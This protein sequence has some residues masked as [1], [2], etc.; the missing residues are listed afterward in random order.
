[1]KANKCLFSNSWG[2]LL[3][4]H[5]VDYLK[6][7]GRTDRR[8]VRHW[9]TDRGHWTSSH[10]LHRW[11]S[12]CPAKHS[13]PHIDT[14][15]QLRSQLRSTLPGRKRPRKNMP[16]AGGWGHA[17][18]ELR[19]CG[20]VDGRDLDG[21]GELVWETD[22]L[23][24]SPKILK[25]IV[26]SGHCEFNDVTK[27]ALE[28]WKDWN[29]TTV[30]FTISQCA[31]TVWVFLGFFVRLTSP[32]LP[33]WRSKDF[34]SMMLL[35][36][37]HKKNRYLEQITLLHHKKMKMCGQASVP[38]FLLSTRKHNEPTGENRLENSVPC[39]VSKIKRD[40]RRAMMVKPFFNI[41]IPTE[42][43]RK[44]E[45]EALSTYCWTACHW[46]WHA[47]N[48]WRKARTR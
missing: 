33:R 9:C 37:K 24:Q 16:V 42:T 41:A 23:Q 38:Y 12:C 31:N 43:K 20:D 14:G 6:S 10:R 1:M 13:L 17:S 22:P 40:T 25:C 11:H 30:S 5:Q 21:I 47:D 45:M 26:I 39:L 46:H 15:R 36:G 18:A 7:A 3:Q 48:Q 35:G 19:T 4:T 28:G 27:W 29:T 44:R 2:A 8:T 34:N 32:F